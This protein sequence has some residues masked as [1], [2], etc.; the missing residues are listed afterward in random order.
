MDGGDAGTAGLIVV[1][2]LRYWPDTSWC[3]AEG[4][5]NGALMKLQEALMVKRRMSLPGQFLME[6]PRVGW[7]PQAA[8]WCV[9]G[10]CGSVAEGSC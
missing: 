2:L 7:E 10:K 3:D 4:A 1:I 6:A 5:E 9:G 8:R